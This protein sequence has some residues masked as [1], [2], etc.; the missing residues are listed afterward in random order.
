MMIQLDTTKLQ[1]NEQAPIIHGFI[2]P[3]HQYPEPKAGVEGVSFPDIPMLRR[4]ITT[5]IIAFGTI[6]VGGEPFDRAKYQDLRID[7][8]SSAIAD[9]AT[10]ATAV[11]QYAQLRAAMEGLACL[12]WMMKNCGR[13]S[14]NAKV[15]GQSS[16]LDTDIR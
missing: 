12:C 13:K 2:A 3:E 8:V 10:N 5:G 6:T 7:L 11:E 14:R 16:K 1:G 15:L 9:P 4:A